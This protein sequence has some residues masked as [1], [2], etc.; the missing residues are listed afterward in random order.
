MCT[1]IQ[2]WISRIGAFFRSRRLD[3]ELELELDSHLNMLEEENLRLGM[4]PQEARRS[5]RLTL[6]GRTQLQEAHRDIR[7]LPLFDSLLQDVRYASRSL[8]KIPGFTGAA[9][10]TLAIG[11]GANTAIFNIVDEALFR[12]LDFP[13]SEELADVFTFNNKS[14]TFLSSSYPDYEDLRA[15]ATTFQTLSAFVRM[16]L[17]VAWRGRDQL[18]PVEAATGNFFSMLALKPVA[19]RAFRDDD[20][21]LG[22]TPVAMVSEG[23]GDAGSVGQII[24]VEEQAFTIVGIVPKRYHGTN[25]NWGDPPQVWIPLQMAARVHP[26]FREISIFQHRSSRWLLIT[27]RMKAGITTEQAQA[28]VRTIAAAIARES[29]SDNRH[30]AQSVFS[31]SRAKFWPAYRVSITGSLTCLAVASG[32]ILLLTCVNLSNLLLSRG[33]TR[34]REFAIR[35]AIGAGY[36]R[37]LRQLLT[38][39]F[40]LVLPSCLASLGIAYGLGQLLAHFPNAL[41]LRLALDGGVENRM[42]YFCL[43]LSVVI[44]V[45]FGL[46]PVFQ[47]TRADVFPAL[48]ESTNTVVRGSPALLQNLFL[49]MQVALSMILLTCA[50]L[51]GRSVIEGW[52]VDP[53]FRLHGLLTVAF[54]GP[55]TGGTSAE[56]LRRSQTELIER[57]REIPSLQSAALASNRPMEMSY[58]LTQIRTTAMTIT[59][60]Q[61]TVGSDFFHTL[62][63]PLLSGRPFNSRD[64]PDASKVAIVNEKLA[65]LLWPSQNPLGQNL[66]AQASTMQVIGIVRDTKY[67]SLWE[68]VRPILYVADGQS[69]RPA[70]YLILRP[71]APTEAHAENFPPIVG[72]EWNRLAPHSPLYDF[73]TGEEL[74]DLA[75]APQRVATGVFG[76]FGLMSVVLAS[77]GLYSLMTYTVTRQTREIGIR[78]AIGGQPTAVVGQVLGQSM[79]V[80]AAGIAVGACLSSL[81]AD[82]VAGE[83]KGISAH[84][85]ATLVVAA[86]LLGGVALLAAAIPARR[87]ARIDPQQALRI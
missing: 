64:N 23:I 26:T 35:I 5:A 10:L 83:V 18:L 45:L 87:A 51:F 3:S 34:Q 22:S 38:E 32:L 52:S 42:L 67:N 58:F 13:R 20:D 50:G 80:A 47:A 16:P 12:P 2:E 37:L 82:F 21:S 55:S 9:V 24:K 49:A 63:M 8:A 85:V 76:A 60:D 14:Q 41:G 11:I 72:K 4:P 70:N 39:S 78:L 36:R 40:L 74:L 46:V 17:N 15:H 29:P 1:P 44:T 86:A 19:G 56:R 69:T 6:G 62:G 66:N 53:G 77:V 75:L 31:A 73:Q 57:L 48:K 79:A 7:G 54:N 30:I 65:S 71:K 68:N 81:L 43:A 59:A 28:E 33:L 61:Q 84:N 25:L 27:G